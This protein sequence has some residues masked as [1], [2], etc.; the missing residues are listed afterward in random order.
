MVLLTGAASR[1]PLCE[2]AVRNTHRQP[3]ARPALSRIGVGCGDR[4]GITRTRPSPGISRFTEKAAGRT[5]LGLILW[6]ERSRPHG[7][8]RGG[9]GKPERNLR[10]FD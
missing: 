10:S 6:D 4:S 8:D 3:R 9:E 5:K 7:K 2:S 1:V